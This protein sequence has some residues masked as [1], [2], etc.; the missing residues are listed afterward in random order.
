MRE[1]ITRK[2]PHSTVTVKRRTPRTDIVFRGI[3]LKL[4]PHLEALATDYDASIN[5]IDLVMYEYAMMC[6]RCNVDGV[7]F[8]IA[9]GRMPEDEILNLFKAWMETDYMDIVLFTR[10]A[11]SE[12]DAP[13]S[14]VTAPNPPSNAKK[15]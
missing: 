14:D 11:I 7:E 1:P 9:T 15:K 3:L 6:A 8:P 10:H 13:A 4:A 5:D 2:F 12:L